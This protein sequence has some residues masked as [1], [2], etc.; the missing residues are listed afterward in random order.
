MRPG[1]RA[2]AATFTQAVPSSAPSGIGAFLTCTTAKTGNTSHLT[3]TAA[4]A[5]FDGMPFLDYYIEWIYSSGPSNGTTILTATRT[6]AYADPT[7]TGMTGTSIIRVT[8]QY[9]TT[10]NTWSSSVSSNYNFTVS[11]DGEA[12]PVC[13]PTK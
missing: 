2:P 9:G 8:A 11:T 12:S 4:P 1:P 6:G 3:W 13:S 5:T 10:A 7:I